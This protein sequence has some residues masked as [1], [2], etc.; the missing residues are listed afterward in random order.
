MMATELIRRLQELV[1]E[2][3]DQRV[4]TPDQMETKWVRDMSDA[5]FDQHRELISLIPDDMD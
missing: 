1:G 2:F 4:T 3:G 5:E